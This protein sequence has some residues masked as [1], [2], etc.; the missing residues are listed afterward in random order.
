MNDSASG[1]TPLENFSNG[2]NIA[3]QVVR[4]HGSISSVMVQGESFK[5]LA[6]TVFFISFY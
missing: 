2:I 6:S 4:S 1:F 3:N 5:I